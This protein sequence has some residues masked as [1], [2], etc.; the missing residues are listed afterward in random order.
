MDEDK[1]KESNI[2]LEYIEYD[3]PEYRQLYKPFNHYVSVLDLLFMTG[4]KANEYIF[5]RKDEG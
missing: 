5:N 3:Y 4:P 1:F 2:R